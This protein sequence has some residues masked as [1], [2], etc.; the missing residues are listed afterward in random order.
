MSAI[1]RSPE[2]RLIDFKVKNAI[3]A[4]KKGSSKEFIIQMF[5]IN[6]RGKSASIT[7]KGFEPFFFVKVGP[8][9]NIG[10]VKSFER[11]LYNKLAYAELDANYRSWESGRR[12]VLIPPLLDG[13]TR[14]LYA[15]R[16]A[17]SY[18]SYHQK[19]VVSFTM[20]KRHQLYGFDNNKLYNFVC[21]TFKNTTCFN[22]LKAFWQNR[23]KDG[24]SLF[25]FR[26]T[27]KNY[28]YHG[29]ATQLYEAALPPLLRFFHINNISPSGW[30]R[31][32]SNKWKASKSKKTLCDFECTIKAS[33]IQ[34]LPNKETATPMKICSFDIE[35]SSSHGDFPV[36]KKT[37][38]KLA[39]ELQM[40]WT[41]NIAEIEK[42]MR[43]EQLNILRNQ[44]L[45][46]YGLAEVESNSISRVFTKEK[47]TREDIEDVF[48]TIATI[49]IKTMV[50]ADRVSADHRQEDSHDDDE[51]YSMKKTW[52]TYIKNKNKKGATY[53]L[54]DCLLD[55]IDVGK[56]VEIMDQFL[57]TCLPPLEG[58]KVTFI[59][60]T[61]LLAGESL[62]RLN[63]GIC[64]NTCTDYG[65]D[66]VELVAC[67]TEREL[68]LEWAAVMRR[69]RPDVIIGYNIFGFDYK[70]MCDRAEEND[71]FK[72]D[73]GMTVTCDCDT[74]CKLGKNKGVSCERLEKE[75]K[76]ASGTHEMTYMKIDGIVQIDLYN[77]FR[78]EVNLGSYK[79]QDVASHFIG[80]MIS[81]VATSDVTETIIHSRNL[82]GLQD[83]NF[84]IF[85][86]IGHS[87]D[88]YNN[89]A[90][91]EV[92]NVI[93]ETGEFTVDI[94]IV[95]PEG[96]RLRWGLGKDDVT[97]QDLF[98]LTNGTADDRQIIAKYCFQDCNLVHH[99][100][101]KNDILTGM[102]EIAALCS[103][104]IDF[105]VMRGQGI[106]LLSFIA[107]KCR[108]KGTL[109]PV[110][111]KVENDGSY[112][113]A[114]CLPPKRGLYIDD[115]VWVGDYASL[116][117]SSMISE[118]I[119]HDSKVWTKE[120]DLGGGHIKT[121]GS[122]EFDNL[123][124]ITY[125]DIEYDR[126]EWISPNGIK[127]EV[128]VKVGTKVCRYAQFADGKKGIMPVILQ[129][130]LSARKATRKLI[131]YE[132]LDLV[133][134]STISGLVNE[135]SEEY[136]V[137]N[138]EGEFCID[139][140]DVVRRYDTYDD[141]T[142]NVFNQRQLAT[143]VVANSL[144]GQCGA[145]T[146][147]FYDKDIA[148]STT[149]AGRKLL[150]YAQKVIESAY[151]DA[152]CDTKYGQVRTKA[153]YIYGDT[154]S[155]FATFHITDMDGIKIGGRKG[156]EITIELAVQACKLASKFLKSP[157]DFEYEK[158]FSPFLLLS[159]KRY[160]GIQ[161]EKNPD[162]CA[163]KSMGIVLKRRDNAD[164]V[165][166]IYG[167][168]I[169]ILMKDGNISK[170]ID[171]TK[172]FLQ[173][174]IDGNVNMSKLVITKALRGW[175]KNPKSIAHKV[176][177]DRIGEREQ[178]K[179][180]AIGSRIPFIYFQTNKKVKLQGDRIEDPDY[181]R[182]HGLVP[183][184]SFYI[185]N[186]IM[187]PLLQMFAL[188]LEEVPEFKPLLSRF[189][190]QL[191]TIKRKYNK[192]TE[193]MEKEEDKLRTAAVKKILFDDA[194]RQSNNR[195]MGQRTIESFFN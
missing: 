105:V 1:N 119:S 92:R 77:Y 145:R 168:N 108:I 175:Y 46:V 118:N 181:M 29:F 79:L 122:E 157:H 163:R 53:T 178:G 72:C 104:P 71:C 13:E 135:S 15:Q 30:I 195:N 88:P 101:R 161:Y 62:P 33:D 93:H 70:F 6:E 164:I 159:K 75:I 32:P 174:I 133:D 114:I 188:V 128:K 185:T 55:N 17:K 14:S 11:E 132:T 76:V 120:Y 190:R 123:P 125:V 150:I 130:L 148:A 84:V 73:C 10:T 85:E 68:L 111:D 139:K 78:R 137:I 107:M 121:T 131:Q 25:G 162:K 48:D 49:G 140:E 153:E 8:D 65:G 182:E 28:L 149:A 96:K 116:Y 134:D 136:T 47:V 60:S 90:K 42:L 138:K 124:N 7:V 113:G 117:P 4:G 129:E 26:N 24:T 69:E 59:G 184:Y 18:Q 20:V 187:K 58:D 56:K 106:K 127:K 173:N 180:P 151:G 5:G 112:E 165:K 169:D 50:G 154:D 80:D 35:A 94:E 19:G 126:Y 37:Y 192:D 102:S 21:I 67:E 38:K 16:N 82:T 43:P 109:M 12:K 156:L 27:L 143:K 144:Y 160:V 172:K 45:S 191:K 141:F 183:D 167:G 52:N 31:L 74:F 54:L 158:T 36:A 44:I 97:P 22:K 89:G 99:L 115:P 103:I 61:F 98:R 57:K 66:D 170:A 166:D 2:F 189:E 41:D 176:L 39:G 51:L 9:W 179:Q 152:V 23:I 87:L 81:S 3:I 86:I 34:P 142:K 100:L 155:V 40:F 171:F 186:Q 83:G 91:Y 95:I 194:L 63:H 177:A 110:I 147:A 64:L 146:S 193:K